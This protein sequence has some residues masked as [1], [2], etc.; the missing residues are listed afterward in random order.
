VTGRRHGA[1]PL[2]ITAALFTRTAT[3]TL[4]LIFAKDDT[5]QSIINKSPP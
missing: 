1:H 2:D 4:S 3:E 5:P